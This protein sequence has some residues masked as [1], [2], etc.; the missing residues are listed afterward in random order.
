[1][2]IIT[3]R[4]FDTES[5]PLESSFSVPLSK[6]AIQKVSQSAVRAQTAR[7]MQDSI[8]SDGYIKKAKRQHPFSKMAA[9]SQYIPLMP[10][11]ICCLIA[12]SIASLP[13]IR[14][15]FAYYS[16][17]I[18]QFYHEPSF[19]R[20]LREYVFP[21]A[22]ELNEQTA[23]PQMPNV[24]YVSVVSFHEHTVKKGETVSGIAG[25]A[26][27]RNI[28]TLLSVN[29][30]DNARRISI[31]QVLTVPSIDGLLHTV[32]KGETL[33]D[34]SA[35]YKVS[36]TALLDANDLT[37]TNLAI[38]QKLFVPGA[39]LS[40][41]DLRKALGELFMYPITGRLTSPFG[42]RADPFTGARSFHSGIDLAAP[43]GTPVKVTLDGKVVET[44]LNRI[45]GNYVIVSHD[46]GY[47]SLYGHLHTIRAKR[48]TYIT[49]GTVIGTV[50]STGYSTGSHLHLSIYK[51]GKMI[52]P[53]SVLK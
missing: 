48:G 17:N 14:H 30:I 8:F 1:M 11:L 7:Y 10:L 6:A 32:K 20:A 2:N 26:G 44:G 23:K 31:G 28:G 47:Q 50:G 4:A 35:A 16:I 25:R 12:W 49:Q 45:F 36:V 27:L 53:L 13:L 19:E 15:K 39:A 37:E 24:N 33:A 41:F 29:G 18:A 38:G 46:R 22:H 52:D 42:Y 5:I 51:N 21:T 40:A 34:I 9:L 3:Y 43:T